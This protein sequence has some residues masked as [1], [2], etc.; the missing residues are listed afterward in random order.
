MYLWANPHLINGRLVHCRIF[1]FQELGRLDFLLFVK[2]VIPNLFFHS[3]L[4]F[5]DLSMLTDASVINLFW[6][7]WNIPLCEYITMYLS[8][9]KAMKLE[10]IF[11][12]LLL[13]T[14]LQ[15]TFLCM[16][17]HAQVGFLSRLRTWLSPSI[18][19][20]AIL[21]PSVAALI[22]TFTLDAVGNSVCAYCPLWVSPIMCISQGDNTKGWTSKGKTDC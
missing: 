5:F 20:G 10:L 4:C 3:A 1:L 8:I 22:Y 6:L 14:K 13:L 11:N 19:D 15:R 21:I 9:S 16:S 7:M 18:L 2:R 17:S 12:F